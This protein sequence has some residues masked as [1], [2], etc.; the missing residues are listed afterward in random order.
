VEA[1]TLVATPAY[2]PRGMPDVASP[3]S[4]LLGM[5]QHQLAGSAGPCIAAAANKQAAGT[6]SG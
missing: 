5:A 2:H 4:C 6:Q 1:A 3:P